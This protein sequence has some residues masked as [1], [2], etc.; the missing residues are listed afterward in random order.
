MLILNIMTGR[1]GR[2]VSDV[3]RVSFPIIKVSFLTKTSYTSK[4][5]RELFAKN[6]WK[7]VKLVTELCMASL[8]HRPHRILNQ[9]SFK[10]K[11][12]GLN[13]CCCSHRTAPFDRPSAWLVRRERAKSMTT[14]QAEASSWP[15]RYGAVRWT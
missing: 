2:F 4:H 14:S 11:A 13:S 3:I 7:N 12:Q 8:T 15:P 10:L 1:L 6:A 9:N 5:H